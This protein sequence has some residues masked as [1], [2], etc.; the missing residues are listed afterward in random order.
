MS[1]FTSMVGGMH[2]GRVRA[3]PRT[4]GQKGRREGGEEEKKPGRSESSPCVIAGL[5]AGVACVCNGALTSDP[6]VLASAHLRHCSCPPCS[7]SSLPNIKPEVFIE[8]FCYITSP[9]TH[10]PMPP[11]PSPSHQPQRS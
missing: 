11:P 3:V 1:R 10:P 2:S 4:K 9:P 5:R 6:L 7:S 8:K